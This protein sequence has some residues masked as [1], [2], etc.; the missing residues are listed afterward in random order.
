MQKST[1]KI[2]KE[3]KI[4]HNFLEWKI[5]KY[6]K[7]KEIREKGTKGVRMN[8]EEL[9]NDRCRTAKGDYVFGNRS[10]GHAYSFVFF[11]FR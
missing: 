11:L 5:P 1:Q 6:A 3:K 4:S 2:I 10:C 7:M 9:A 8:T